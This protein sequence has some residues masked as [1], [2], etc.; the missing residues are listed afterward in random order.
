MIDVKGSRLTILRQST[1]LTPILGAVNDKFTQI[2][3]D[4]TTHGSIWQSL[5]SHFKQRQ[6]FSQFNQSFR[7]F[8][9]G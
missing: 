7:F 4:M 8:A 1:V 6:K 5:G 9:L 2:T 3:G